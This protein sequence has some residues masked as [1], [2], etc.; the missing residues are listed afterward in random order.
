MRPQLRRYQT[1]SPPSTL[2]YYSE[3]EEVTIDSVL[4]PQEGSHA[5]RGKHT[6]RTVRCDSITL[7]AVLPQY[8]Y[9]H[10]LDVLPTVL[11]HVYGAPVEIGHSSPR[12]QRNSLKK[13]RRN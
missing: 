13:P 12:L 1:Q 8:V 7:D 6:L 11:T 4:F 3:W 9:R 5:G 2:I 10:G